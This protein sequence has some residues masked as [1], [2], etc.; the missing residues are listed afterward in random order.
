MF[1]LHSR[2]IRVCVTL[3]PEVALAEGQHKGQ[4]EESEED[5]HVEDEAPTAHTAGQILSVIVLRVQSEAQSTVAAYSSIHAE[6]RT[7]S[8]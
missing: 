3:E 8:H 5:Q 7:A 4:H 6:K 2:L 1:E